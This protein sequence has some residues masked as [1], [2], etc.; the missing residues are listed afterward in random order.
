M[1]LKE[2]E[3]SLQNFAELLIERLL[4]RNTKTGFFLTDD[5]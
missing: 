1:I 2:F 4:A 3:P 5:L